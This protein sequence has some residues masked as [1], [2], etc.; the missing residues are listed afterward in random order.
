MMDV[1]WH[2]TEWELRAVV[3]PFGKEGRSG[4]TVSRV[5]EFGQK[6]L[7][8]AEVNWPATGAQSLG[9]TYAFA[10]GLKRA[11]EIGHLM[12]GRVYMYKVRGQFEGEEIASWLCLGNNPE[13]VKDSKYGSDI[14]IIDVTEVEDE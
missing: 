13:Q 14:T 12:N 9:L 3:Y 11:V 4:I 6:E 8:Q 1:K 7:R 10:L 5:H 2:N